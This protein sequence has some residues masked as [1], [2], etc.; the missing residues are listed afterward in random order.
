MTM[1]RSFTPALLLLLSALAPATLTQ[2]GG[3]ASDGGGPSQLGT[4]TGNPPVIKKEALHL[5][6]AP[7][8]MRL[9]GTPGAVTP[10]AEVR[11]TNQR[12]GATAQT[13]AAADGS[14]DVLVSGESSDVYEVTVVS[15][16]L[17][18]SVTLTAADLPG[19]LSTLSCN[20]LENSLGSVL[21]DAFGDADLS[22]TLESDCAEFGLGQGNCYNRCGTSIASV[23]G[24]AEALTEGTQRVAPV[25]AEID[26]RGCLNAAPPCIPPATVT[27]LCEAGRCVGRA[28]SELSCDEL[29]RQAALRRQQEREEDNTCS[30]DA[31]C[32]LV[33][34]PL[35]CIADCGDP[36]AIPVVRV[37][38]LESRL[39]SLE[40]EFCGQVT[41]SGCP[42]PAYPSCELHE[43]TPV[44]QC[45]QGQC[46]LRY[47][48]F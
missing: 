1:K 15:D 3:S 44:A 25:C 38:S 6:V 45:V 21:R 10:G 37:G 11:V 18:T 30:V 43:G 20:A 31:D 5:E 17:E 32:T 46:S 8:G 40:Q 26:R 47:V 33:E 24:G 12:T 23:S 13:L 35:S 29:T 28:T 14:L 27:I 7:G 19:D 16:G 4:E 22:C 36:T 39:Q 41:S 34:D 2:C 42:P 48:D 9:I